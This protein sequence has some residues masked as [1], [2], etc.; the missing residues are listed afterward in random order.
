MAS[1]LDSSPN[2]RSRGGFL[3]GHYFDNARTPRAHGR[4]AHRVAH[5]G[6]TPAMFTVEW[7]INQPGPHGNRII[8]GPLIGRTCNSTVQS[9][10]LGMQRVLMGLRSQQSRTTQISIGARWS[11]PVLTSPKIVRSGLT[12]SGP[13]GTIARPC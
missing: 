9:V 11:V 3:N 13:V 8:R 1:R 12:V 7:A 2:G 10:K 5:A 4:L 6:L